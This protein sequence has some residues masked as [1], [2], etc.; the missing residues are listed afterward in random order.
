MPKR[1]NTTARNTAAAAGLEKRLRAAQAEIKR[2]RAKTR[3]CICGPY[4]DED[5]A[6]DIRELVEIINKLPASAYKPGAV[7]NPQGGTDADCA[8]QHIHK[9]QA[10]STT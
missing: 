5:K 7:Y 1:Q 4:T 8:Q 6:D 10:A 3:D 2:L 9:N